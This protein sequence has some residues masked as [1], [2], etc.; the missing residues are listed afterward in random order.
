MPAKVVRA[1]RRL[2]PEEMNALLADE[3]TPNPAKCNHGRRLCGLKLSI[4]KLFEGDDS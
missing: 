4:R 1:G 2:K 3:N